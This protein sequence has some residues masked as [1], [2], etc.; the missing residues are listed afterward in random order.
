MS[1]TRVLIVDDSAIMRQLLTEILSQDPSLEVVGSASDP[2]VARDKIKALHPDVL[3]L[4]VEM[5]R[6]DGLSFLEK[7]MRAHPM[8][9]LMISSLTEQGAATTLRAM[10]LGAVDFVTKPKL[11]VRT[12]TLD[13]ADEIVEKVKAASRAHVRPR[14]APDGAPRAAATVAHAPAG[15][16]LQGTPKVIAVGASTGGTVALREFLVPLPPDTP[17]I[18]IVQHMPANFTKSF[19]ERLDSQCQMRVKE[20]VDG[21]RILPG[22]VLIA[23]GNFH[24]SVQRSGA[25]YSVR[26]FSAEPVNRHRPSV[27]VLFDSCAQAVGANALG[28]ILTGMGND[29]AKGMFAMRRAGARTF[30]QDEASCVV[31]GMPREAI[32]AGGAEHTLPLHDL[33]QALLRTLTGGGR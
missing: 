18:V 21:D 20:A 29:G 22:H 15:A 5:P 3:T 32:L 1:K 17:G 7:L 13:L 27:D 30:A 10:E 8:P 14:R 28:V 6:M 11:D 24:M 16:L 9:V 31:F 12:G 25:S 23:P 4:D 33:P 19:A 2:F 26:V